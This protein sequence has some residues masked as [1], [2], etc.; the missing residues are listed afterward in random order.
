MKKTIILI[1]CCIG[2]FFIFSNY[3]Q[4]DANLEIRNLKVG[5]RVRTFRLFVPANLPKDKKIPL[6]FVFH[7]GGG[8]GLKTERL[9]KFSRVA[10]RE[11]FIVVYP[12]GVDKNW[13][14][15]RESRNIPAQKQN[16]DDIAFVQA[17]IESLSKEYRIDEKR[18]FATG[19]SNGGIFSHYVGVNLSDKFA[20]IAPVAG[21][22]AD[23]FYKNA[24][25]KKPVSV[26]ILQG[27]DDPLVPYNGGVVAA[28][29]SAGRG[30]IA[31]TDEAIRFWT[32]VDQTSKE[33][34]KGTLA[35][36]DK[37]DGCTVETFLWKGGKDGTEVKLY[38]QNGAGHTWPGSYQYLPK[39]LIG[40]VCRD[41][42][43]TEEIWNFFKEHPK[44]D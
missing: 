32:S 24:Q 38:K 7:G 5:D 13:N 35:D 3:Q 15:G 37:N 19:I 10:E 20:A 16:V 25:P 41:F 43:A 21:G 18:I 12:E 26:F 28:R 22:I 31:S 36:I 14:D 23:P 17:M 33:P 9:T 42:D 44:R 30:R 11:K 1:V 29:I 8:D 40:N 2:M 4:A 34:L 27:T 39:F 6:V